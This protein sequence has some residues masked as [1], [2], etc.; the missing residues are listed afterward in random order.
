ML[1]LR[2]R[3]LTKQDVWLIQ[4]PHRLKQPH[5]LSPRG[6]DVLV[7]TAIIILLDDAIDDKA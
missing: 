2:C 6:K 1:A 4:M 5:Q 7:V 3:V